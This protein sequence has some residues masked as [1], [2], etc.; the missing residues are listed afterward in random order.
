MKL[1]IVLIFI[2]G[3]FLTAENNKPKIKPRTVAA[4][5]GDNPC[6]ACKNC[7]YWK[8]CAKDGKTCGV[9]K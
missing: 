4:C 2:F 6:R 1:L 7:K 8:R 5:V 9:C 3:T